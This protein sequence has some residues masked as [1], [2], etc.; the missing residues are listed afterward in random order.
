MGEKQGREKNENNFCTHRQ[1]KKRSTHAYIC[2]AMVRSAWL[3]FKTVVSGE[4][5]GGQIT[6]QYGK[7]FALE[8]VKVYKMCNAATNPDIRHAKMSSWG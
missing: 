7:E 5:L 8:E 6:G 3:G 4:V 2:W 1:K